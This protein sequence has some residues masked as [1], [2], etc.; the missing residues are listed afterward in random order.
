[1]PVTDAELLDAYKTAELAIVSGQTQAYTVN[2]RAWTGLSLK[3]LRER[4]AELEQKIARS[5]RRVFAVGTFR[6]AR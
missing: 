1:M 3:E 5:G 2:G 6:S 4:I